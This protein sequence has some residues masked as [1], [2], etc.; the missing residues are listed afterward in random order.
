WEETFHEFNDWLS[1]CAL[2]V[3]AGVQ[4]KY[5]QFRAERG[6]VTFDDQI[7]FALALTSVPEVIARIRAKDY[8]VILDEA[9]DTDP[10]QFAILTEI[11]RPANATGRWIDNRQAQLP[12]PPPSHGYDLTGPQPG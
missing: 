3:A 10:E 2:K 7:A 9:Q 8:I 6:A 11:T 4:A 12:L 5:R 1:C